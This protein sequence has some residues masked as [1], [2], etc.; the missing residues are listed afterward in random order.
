M[1]LTSTISWLSV[2]EIRLNYLGGPHLIRW[3]ALHAEFRFP[4]GRENCTCWLSLQLVPKS[5]SLLDCLPYGFLNLPRHPSQPRKLILQVLFL[6]WN[7]DWYTCHAQSIP[8]SSPRRQWPWYMHN[9]QVVTTGGCQP[10][11]LFSSFPLERSEQPMFM[12]ATFTM[13]T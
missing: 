1:S 3:K 12:D 11:I 13:I 7:S 10:S 5:S 6:W 9:P 8:E 2:T 4:W